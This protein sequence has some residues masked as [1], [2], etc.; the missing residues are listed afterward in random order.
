MNPEKY[1]NRFRIATSR[2]GWW[3]YDNDAFYF[4]T[5]CTKNRIPYFGLIANGIAHKTSVASRAEECWLKIPEHYPF[6]K[7][8]EYVVMPNHFHGILEICKIGQDQ[9]AELPPDCLFIKGLHESNDNPRP[10]RFA[11]QSNNLAAIIRGF[12]I[13][14]TSFAREHLLEFDWQPRYHD[15]IIRSQEELNNK[16]WYIKHNPKNW[17]EDEFHPDKK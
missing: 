12:K 8:H 15:R 3:N 16:K 1:K 5:I 13:G 2:A 11:P 7:V 17:K 10:N 4:I 6:V 9:A 14:V